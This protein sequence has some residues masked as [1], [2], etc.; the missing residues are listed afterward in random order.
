MHFLIGKKAII[1]LTKE[2]MILNLKR[3]KRIVT[4]GMSGFIMSITNSIVQI[5]VSYTH[6]VIGIIACVTIL[7]SF[8]LTFE[9]SINKFKHKNYMPSFYKLSNFVIKHY[10]SFALLFVIMLIP[11]VYGYNNTN[12]YYDLYDTLP[13]SAK[14]IQAN[15]ELKNDFDI[16]SSH[17]I[18]LISKIEGYLQYSYPFSY[19]QQF[20][21]LFPLLFLQNPKLFYKNP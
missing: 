10:K 16:G 13:S 15:N 9:K 12:V 3:I 7:P 2:S 20:F 14:S 1:K 8:I 18:L 21:H 19:L 5:A 6:L 11:A 4:L 17:I